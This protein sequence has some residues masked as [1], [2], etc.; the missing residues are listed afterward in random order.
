MTQPRSLR[1]LTLVAVT[2][3]ALLGMGAAKL[4]APTSATAAAGSGT[5]VIAYSS[6]PA[7]LDP[8]TSFELAGGVILRGTYE[9]LVR[10]AGR[11]TTRI[12]GVLATSWRSSQGGRVWTFQLRRNVR[13]HDGTP[14]TATAVR[15]SYARVINVDQG[16]AFIVGQFVKPSNIQVLGRYTVRFRLKAPSD[17]FLRALASQWGTWIVSPR[18]LRQHR[19]NLHSWLQTHD[20]GTGPYVL[21]RIVPGQSTTL[22]RFNGYWRG[23]KGRHVSRVIVNV[24]QAT[25]TR[26][27]QIERGDADLAESLTPGDLVALRRNR[28]VVVDASYGM[29]NLEMVMTKVGPLRSP[30]ARRAMAYAFDYR[31]FI[32]QVLRGYGRQAQGPTPRTL[33]GHDFSLPLYATN[34]RKART[35][36]R[37]AGVKSGTRLT[38]MFNTA[39]EEA[40]NAALI[41]QVQ[42]AKL[43]LS[44][45]L[46]G[47][48]NSSLVDL[49]YG[50]TPPSR[51]PNLIVWDEAP[52]YNDPGDWLFPFY[53]S[54]MAGSKGANGGF[55]ANRTVDRLLQRAALMANTGQRLKLYKQVQHIVAWDDPAAVFLVDLATST[56]YRRNLH[57]YYLNPVYTGTYDLYAMWKS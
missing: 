9:G 15:E 35:L 12:Q 44:L 42:L 16:P 4:R 18:A 10:T 31:A 20:A 26:R 53:D 51:R 49:Y 32:N 6:A 19:R 7:D 56:V 45:N 13:F 27:A 50:D 5:L 33:L 48:D 40:R 22:T 17:V 46:Q 47:R 38:V 30:L 21:S 2:I 8:F 23:W 3:L 36:L 25:A 37:Q 55:Y 57:G 34:L 54:K 14:F 29:A 39:N 41:M 28:S 43:G 52:D 11:S 24:V 1:R